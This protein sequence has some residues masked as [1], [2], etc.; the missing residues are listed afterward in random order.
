M[1][2]YQGIASF[3]FVTSSESVWRDSLEYTY[4]GCKAKKNCLKMQSADR[5]QVF[6]RL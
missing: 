3:V 2:N 1:L 5:L 6:L 4:F